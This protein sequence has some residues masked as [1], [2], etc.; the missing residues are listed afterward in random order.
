MEL[1]VKGIQKTY[2]RFGLDVSIEVLPGQ[3][4]GLVGKNGAD[5]LSQPWS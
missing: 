3:I 5:D 4:T 2:G 1:Q